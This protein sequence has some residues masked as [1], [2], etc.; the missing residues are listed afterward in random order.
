MTTHSKERIDRPRVARILGILAPILLPL[1]GLLATAPAAAQGLSWEPLGPYA[2]GL[3][4][5]PGV[6]SS[7]HLYASQR[8][9]SGLYRS[10]DRG[11]VWQ[12]LSSESMRAFAAS[13]RTLMI[14]DNSRL[15]RSTDDG[16]TWRALAPR[17]AD[18]D[19]VVTDIAFARD[20]WYAVTRSIRSSSTRRLLRSTDDGESWTT[21]IAG[22]PRLLDILSITGDGAILAT[23][24]TLTA[25]STD[26]GA[27]WTPIV[28]AG[29]RLRTIGRDGAGR[30]YSVDRDSIIESADG[31]LSWSAVARLPVPATADIAVTSDGAI[32]LAAHAG[33]WTTIDR[34]ATWQQWSADSVF[35][36]TLIYAVG[37]DLFLAG[38]SLFNG[39][40]LRSVDRGRTFVPASRGL[41]GSRV[42]TVV[43]LRDGSLLVTSGA[44]TL[45]WAPG[46]SAW[47]DPKVPGMSVERGSD[48]A[49]YALGT[50]GNSFRT[51][52]HFHV[53]TDEGSTWRVSDSADSWFTNVYGVGPD[54]EFIAAT[55]RRAILATS[56]L[57]ATWRRL[58]GDFFERVTVVRFDSIGGVLVGTEGAG[59][60]RYDRAAGRFLALNARA[61][62]ATINDIVVTPAGHIFLATAD[63][64]IRR[65]TDGGLSF[66]DAA[67]GL[68]T[69]GVTR[70]AA[71]P[72]GVLLAATGS[73]LYLSRSNGAWWGFEGEGI[74][75]G[76]SSIA[77]DASG[78]IIVGTS[79]GAFISRE[80]AS[81]VQ[82]APASA[83]SIQLRV[84]PNP[85]GSHAR[86]ELSGGH[87]D[88]ELRVVDPRGRTVVRSTI[89]ARAGGARVIDLEG[90]APGAYRVVVE[91]DGRTCSGPLHVVR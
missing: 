91:R 41:P 58:D 28:G 30:Y 74:P 10:T 1:L 17:P 52:N 25:R 48:G 45:K 66:D 47:F 31:G 90:L 53:S 36:P 88:A 67:G 65:S 19:T 71:S 49:L 29:D 14:I 56:D 26:E 5:T 55:T 11:G 54:G 57:G 13:S 37:N 9:S 39:G 40:V 87:G 3:Y 27:S 46:S 23:L 6:D 60:F 4:E 84:A 21:M 80:Q 2:G 43:P 86:V 81:S 73:G 59:A 12:R 61:S 70:L 64:G 89:D 75:L 68:P 24:D 82:P 72:T 44:A 18:E 16:R 38:S 22:V 8:G 35:V 33:V 42:S 69:P 7:G 62:S 50:G 15:L 63:R 32:G 76:V 79:S 77:F 34:G 20:R 83:P 85:A 51:P 78:R